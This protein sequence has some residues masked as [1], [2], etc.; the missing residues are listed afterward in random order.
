MTAMLLEGAITLVLG[1]TMMR[2]GFR[3]GYKSGFRDG[4]L[5][6]MRFGDRKK[7]EPYWNN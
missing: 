5:R 2:V 1:L 6:A 3:M 7:H 4:T